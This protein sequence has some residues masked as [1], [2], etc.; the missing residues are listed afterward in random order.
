MMVCRGCG[1]V[2]EAC[3]PYPFTCP[4]A[5]DG[6]DH[7]MR[8]V[9][10]IEALAFPPVTHGEH[11]P[12]VAF[13]SLLHSQH[14]AVAGGMTH[15]AYVRLVGDLDDAVA[16]VDGHG[17]A[18]TP[19]TMQVALAERC[20]LLGPLYVKDET[21]NVSGS[22]KGRHLFGLGVHLAVVERLGLA[23]ASERRPLAIASCGNAA[24]AAAVVAAAGERELLVF[25]PTDADPVVVDR[26]SEL[27]ARITVCERQPGVPGDP[28]YHRMRTAI[29]DGALPFTCQGN[30]NGLAIEGG[31]TL[32]YEMVAQ[33]AATDAPLD[34]I[35]V[36]V[37]G[38]ALASAVA[39]AFGEAVSFGIIE[40]QPRF[41]TVQTESA[42]PLKRA[43]DRVV[44]L[45][46][47]ESGPDPVHK[48]L[49]H[50]AH[51]RAEFMWPWETAPHSIAHG[52]LDDETY[53]WLAVVEAM[54]VTGGRSVVVGEEQL[55]AANAL[56]LDTTGI[57]V[58][59]TGSS[60]LAGLVALQQQGVI[61]PGE[62]AAVLFTG[63]RR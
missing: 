52:I 7:V 26:L 10:D 44:A 60:G 57:E 63:A 17:F 47:T 8:R 41:H 12:F 6:N 21:G 45:L 15:D 19:L 27:G 53:D 32:G 2:A 54:L 35:V 36:Q 40:R 46:G 55:A 30:E 25:V 14:L 34:H 58:D 37:G 1:S 33:L 42:W 4:N 51:H 5:G 3:E 22:H 9:L 11:N 38:G 16:K 48:T 24:L 49:R 43:F 62:S 29:A 13:R 28:T 20:G 50:A 39:A 18:T 61:G 59:P 23:D 56:A 31:Q